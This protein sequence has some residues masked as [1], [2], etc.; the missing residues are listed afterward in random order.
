MPR[1][2]PE[3][4]AF[5]ERGG[6]TLRCHTMPMLQTQSVAA[7][8]YGVAWWCHLLSGESG[9]SAKLLM[10]A[11]KHDVAEHETGDVPSPTKDALKIRSLLN[12]YE[13]RL[14]ESAGLPVL[15]LTGNE[16]RILK[17]ADSLELMQ[18]CVRERRYGN[19]HDEIAE[20]FANVRRYADTLLVAAID[21]EAFTLVV[22]NWEKVNER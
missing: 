20:M 12:A 5:I 15:H 19:R 3:T 6:R 16:D 9:A 7:H 1:L 21:H 4:V 2:N 14:E 17:L 8:S 11:L 13:A 22:K 10:A 18:H